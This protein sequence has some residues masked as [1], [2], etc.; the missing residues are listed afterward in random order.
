[1]KVKHKQA[2]DNCSDVQHL[3]TNLEYKLKPHRM[4]TKFLRARIDTCSIVNVMPVSVYHVMYKDPDCTKLATKKKNGIYTYI[5]EK[6]QVIVSCELFVIHPNAMCLQAVTFQI[7]NTEGRVIVSCS[8]SISLN[9]IQIHSAL[10]A[11]VP[12]SGQLIYSYAD[13]P[14]KYK[15]K[16]LKSSVH[17]CDNASAR[18]VQPPKKPKAV[19]TDV[20]QRKNPV[21][22]DNKKQRCQAKDNIMCYGKKS[23]ETQ[24]MRP[25]KPPIHMQSV[26]S[27]RNKKPKVK[28]QEDNRNCQ[29]NRRPMKSQLN[30][31]KNYQSR[32][33]KSPRQPMCDDRK[34]PSTM[35]K[36][37]SGK[38]CQ[39]TQFMQPAKLEY[40]RFCKDQTCH[41][42][43]CYKKHSDPKKR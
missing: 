29:E 14:E 36:V 23:K 38:N 32:C 20:A 26:T 28:L 33:L 30:D 27:S 18:E 42:T 40:R 12:D 17:I 22:Q 11:S 35:K 2:E 10:N 7:V 43:R 8:T 34:C 21:V 6:I 37:C 13:D 24:F 9:L 16:K 1:M 31:E 19:K 4:R 41:S 15:Y 5:T 39:E 3:V 25:A